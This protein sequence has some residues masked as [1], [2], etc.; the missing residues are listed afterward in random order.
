MT[1]ELHVKI[2]K[3]GTHCP[4]L[5]TPEEGHKLIAALMLADYILP[6]SLDECAIRSPP[7]GLEYAYPH[8]TEQEKQTFSSFSPGRLCC[9][10]SGRSV[11]FAIS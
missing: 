8:P 1:D 10:T 11:S 4:R 6:N 2:N 5:S 3:I 7:Q 9:A